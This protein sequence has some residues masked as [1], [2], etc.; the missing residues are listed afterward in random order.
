M[1]RS[2]LLKKAFWAMRA[3]FH[4]FAFSS[5]TFD[6]F[7][8]LK[9]MLRFKIELFTSMFQRFSSWL[10]IDFAAQKR[11]K[12]IDKKVKAKLRIYQIRTFERFCENSKGWKHIDEFW[13]FLSI[14][15]NA[16]YQN[17]PFYFYI[18]KVF[19]LTQHCLYC[20]KKVKCL[21]YESY[22]SGSWFSN[23]VN[24]SSLANFFGLACLNYF[25]FHWL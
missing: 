19:K 12:V 1:S 5:M 20:T 13:P 14:K 21:R 7:C 18:S 4:I 24:A 8:A 2:I 10:S 3:I 6:L 17:W 9:T 11:S 15:V 22:E 25:Q 23:T 16:E